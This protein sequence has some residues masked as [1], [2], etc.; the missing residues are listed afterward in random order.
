[1]K[2]R[3]SNIYEMG[4]DLTQRGKD[5]YL[6]KANKESGQY[7]QIKQAEHNV[8]NAFKT[9]PWQELGIANHGGNY[10]ITLPQNI[11]DALTAFRQL[12]PNRADLFGNWFGLDGQNGIYMRVDS[13]TNRSHFPNGGIPDS[14]KGTGLGYKCYRRLL[15]HAKWLTSNTGGSAIKNNAWASMIKKRE[16]PDDVHAIV[17]PTQVLAMVKQLPNSQKIE[18][19]DKFIQNSILPQIEKITA[20]NFAIDDELERI[21]PQQTLQILDPAHRAA[22]KQQRDAAEAEATR[23][24]TERER[25]ASDEL[26]PRFGVTTIDHSFRP[27]DVVIRYTM[28]NNNT[29]KPRIVAR[30]GNE[31]K[32]VP[33]SGYIEMSRD[34]N[35]VPVEHR[36]LNDTWTKINPASIPDLNDV[37]LD[38]NEQAYLRFLIQAGQTSAPAPHTD[39]AHDL[40]I[41]TLRRDQQQGQSFQTGPVI[42]IYNTETY[43]DIANSRIPQLPE[44]ARVKLKQEDFIQSIYMTVE[45]Y[46]RYTDKKSSEVFAGFSGTLTHMTLSHGYPQKAVNTITGFVVD[47]P[48]RKPFAAKFSMTKLRDRNDVRAG[49][50]VYIATHPVYFG[51]TGRVAYSASAGQREFVSIEMFHPEI[52]GE[53]GRK[54]PIAPQFL[55]KLRMTT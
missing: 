28:L 29:V 14:L 7:K 16:E 30:V 40:A 50:M 17:G 37:R 2:Q 9:V 31:L 3:I 12:D 32:A 35:H 8:L 53:K 34:I 41:R 33:I 26:R 11:K 1:M 22:A 48:N 20:H 45:Q 47:D 52:Q 5:S 27:G 51:L 21:L 39:Q 19:A 44:A 55:R 18:I 42:T 10:Y 6:G 38:G 43:F 4:I 54:V 24:R 23:R 49:D 13:G 25:Q 15:D 36:D 46:A